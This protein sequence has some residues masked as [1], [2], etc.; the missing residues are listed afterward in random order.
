[1]APLALLSLIALLISSTLATPLSE[2]ASTG[3][4][5]STSQGAVT[6]TLV[7]PTVR[8]FLGIPYAQAARWTP[9]SPPPVRSGT[10]SATAFGQSC[11]ETLDATHTEFLKL[12]GA[13]TAGANGQPLVEG[14]DCLSVNIWA[15]SVD[16]KQG[17]AVLLWIYGG[18]FQFG[19]SNFAAYIGRQFV[20]AND[21]ITVV[22]FNYRMNIFGQPN[23]PQFVPNA[24]SGAQAQNFG[25]LDVNAAIEWVHA[26]I[27]DFGGDPERITIFGQSAG[28]VAVDA[29]VYSHANGGRVKGVIMESGT[30][31][32]V[33]SV[34][35]AKIGTNQANVNVWQ[36]VAKAVGCGTDPTDAQLAC[37][38]AVDANVLE[39]AVLNT[40]TTF[41]V[42]VDDVTIFSDT[43]QRAIA[44]NFLHVPML[45][46]TTAQE[47]DIFVVEEEIL[48]LDFAIPGVTTVVSNAVTKVAFTCPASEAAT[49]RVNAG[50][51]TWRYQYDAV[52]PDISTRSDLRAYHASEIPIVFATYNASTAG[53][54]ATQNEIALSQYV[55]SAWVAFARDPTSG[56]AGGP[57]SWPEYGATKDVVL[58]GNSKNPKAAT[59]VAA[60]QVDSDCGIIDSLVAVY[61]EL[62]LL[63]DL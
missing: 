9:P 31:D 55:Q 13:G 43:R 28:S 12:S 37:M 60:G 58:L 52:F 5:I 42:I 17:T 3:L 32:L 14:D 2:R 15:P 29:Y 26:N 50:V 51:P 1:M 62:G 30:L 41:D 34:P 38:R 24:T 45:T 10:F 36:T 47:G 46:G 18:S 22:T 59:F 19:T 11:V 33:L 8:Q 49:D 39:T 54:P 48:T 27:A 25:L 57:F 35:I 56:L 53:V 40:G 4:T 21:D 44:G 61:N 63:V 20:E 16:R 6:G 23:A 7:S